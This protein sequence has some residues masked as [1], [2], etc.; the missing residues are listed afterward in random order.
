MVLIQQSDL[1]N[2]PLPEEGLAQVKRSRKASEKSR[3]KAN[4]TKRR[5]NQ[6]LEDLIPLVRQAL[7]QLSPA[8]ADLKAEL[9]LQIDAA[10]AHL[11]DQGIC[12][13]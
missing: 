6:I 5:G 10:D 3:V 7:A 9:K 1:D 12:L 11:R 4:R 2:F 8:Q 13:P